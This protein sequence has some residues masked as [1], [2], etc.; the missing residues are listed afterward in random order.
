MVQLSGTGLY[1]V[2]LLFVVIP[3]VFQG[4]LG[5]LAGIEPNNMHITTLDL[6]SRV[7]VVLSAGALVSTSFF[8]SIRKNAPAKYVPSTAFPVFRLLLHKWLDVEQAF[9]SWNLYGP[10]FGAGLFVH[11]AGGH[12][13]TFCSVYLSVLFLFVGALCVANMHYLLCL[14]LKE[15][16]SFPS[17]SPLPAPSAI[18][19]S[20]R[21]VLDCV[22]LVLSIAGALFFFPVAS[23]NWSSWG[24][25]PGQLTVGGWTDFFCIQ[26]TPSVCRA[27]LT[28]GYT[29]FP[30]K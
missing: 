18:S 21:P 13:W 5:P 28:H 8:C 4:T 12:H 25:C 29:L 14:L 11:L 1:T 24:G 3:V 7:F 22:S 9:A 10:L 20:L 26:L 15:H 19:G 27:E 30:M 17:W 6:F 2:L 16:T 23:D